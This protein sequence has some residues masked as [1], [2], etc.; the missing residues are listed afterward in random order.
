[1]TL[2]ATYARP[3]SHYRTGSYS[4]LLRDDAPYYKTTPVDIDKAARA[5][6]DALTASGLWKDDSQVAVLVANKKYVQQGTPGLNIVI[7]DL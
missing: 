5:A 1:M 7:G 3:K 6:L 2:E 4:H